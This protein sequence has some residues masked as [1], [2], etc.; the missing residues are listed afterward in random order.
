MRGAA[1]EERTQHAEHGTGMASELSKDHLGCRSPSR[2]AA[3]S[4]FSFPE[5]AKVLIDMVGGVLAGV[6]FPGG[7]DDVITRGHREGSQESL[8][9]GEEEGSPAH[10]PQR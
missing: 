6:D 2:P 1:S 8:R 9:K 7:P 5:L 10:R 4:G 3:R